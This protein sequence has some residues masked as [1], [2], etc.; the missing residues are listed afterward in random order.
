MIPNVAQA[1][2][3]QNGHFTVPWRKFLAALDRASSQSGTDTSGLASDI[4]ALATALGSPDGTVANIPEA[5]GLIVCNNGTILVTPD[6][7]QTVIGL[8][9]F[10][11]SGVGAALVKIT[12]DLYGRV[13]GTQ[14]A[15][16]SDLAEGSNLYYTDERAQDAIAA[17]IAAGTRTGITITY[18]DA[19]NKFD[20]T[21]AGGVGGVGMSL[22]ASAT[23]SGSAASILTV[24]G[25][26]LAAYKSFFI[27]FSLKNATASASN[28]SLLFNGDTTAA[29]YARQ[30]M[31]VSSTSTAPSRGSDSIVDSLPA[32]ECA[33]GDIRITQDI[34]GRARAYYTAV[35]D[36]AANIT[37][38]CAGIRWATVA[39][40]TS[41]SISSAVANALAVGSRID[42]YG[43]A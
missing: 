35:R 41:I 32:S 38:R 2:V 4:A 11:D 27:V 9:A 21:V 15:T 37:W 40:V 29:N 14:A 26:S 31:T 1:A 42:V 28:L 6:G 33:A 30:G 3:D 19:A 24:S 10:G 7:S 13:Q 36:S 16:T 20:F 25:L 18:N 5:A 22:L 39:D 43:N 34:D 23:V 12:R 17:A 8:K